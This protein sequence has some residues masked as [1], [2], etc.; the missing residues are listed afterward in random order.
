MSRLR[1]STLR[2]LAETILCHYNLQKV[3]VKKQGI[4]VPEYSYII[5]YGFIVGYT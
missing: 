2:D 3:G 4:L 1:H 5:D